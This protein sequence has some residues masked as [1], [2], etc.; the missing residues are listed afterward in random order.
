MSEPL[1][2]YIPLVDAEPETA[3]EELPGTTPALEPATEPNRPLTAEAASCFV[4]KEIG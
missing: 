3:D 4:P 1:G 2:C